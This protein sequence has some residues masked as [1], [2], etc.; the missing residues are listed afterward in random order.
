METESK[1]S[2]ISVV[3]TGY[4]AAETNIVEIRINVHKTTETLKQSKDEVARNVHYLYN[5]FKENNLSKKKFF[6]TS[7]DFGPEYS[8]KNNGKVFIGQKYEQNL[9]YVV[10]DIKNYLDTIINILDT[11]ASR[12][13]SIKYSLLFK[14]SENE[15]ITV[16]C[17]ELA[18]QDGLEKAKKYARM[19]GIKIIKA[20]KISENPPMPNAGRNESDASLHEESVS[21]SEQIPLGMIEKSIKLYMD[22]SAG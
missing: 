1:T 21:S 6:T 3:G 10:E 19:A 22:F 18:Y 9:I 20:V 13:D 5:T 14:I 11:I 7:I 15:D 8:V 4:I 2:I 17:R 16:K 12:N